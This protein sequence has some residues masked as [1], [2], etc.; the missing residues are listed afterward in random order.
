MSNRGRQNIASFLIH[1]LQ[2]DWR[3]GGDY[4]ESTLIDYDVYSNWVV[5]Y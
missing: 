1:D 4:F 2:Q 3:I 5:S